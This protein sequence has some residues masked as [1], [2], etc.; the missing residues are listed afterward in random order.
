MT[1]SGELPQPRTPAGVAGLRALVEHPGEA[2][3]AFDFDGVLS[4]I[5]DDPERAFAHPAVVPALS[6]LAPHFRALAIVTGRPAE[7]VVRLGGFA[8]VPELAGLLVVGHYGEER[9][10]ARTGEITAPSVDPGVE[11]V[12]RGLPELLSRLGAPPG[13]AIEDKGRAVAVHFRRA[14]DPAAAGALLTEP[15][16]EL[17]SAHGLSVQP[18]R[19]VLELKPA[20]M[21]KGTALRSLVAEVGVRAVSYT[22]DDLGDLPAYD[23]VEELRS[24]G[25]DGLLVCSGSTEVT[26]LAERADI[27]VDGPAGVVAFLSAL[28]ARFGS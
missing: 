4:P 27:V 1:V 21:H 24:E 10:D 12:R 11:E 9:W 7:V 5:V 15:L 22:G 28:A 16:T 14:A 3:L 17:A 2:M 13:T 19:M 6:R 23:A 26:A 25:L 20:G 18:G 8:G